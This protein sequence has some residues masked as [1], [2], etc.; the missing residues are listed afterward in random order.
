MSHVSTRKNRN[1]LICLEKTVTVF[2]A[3]FVLQYFAS[4]NSKC[5]RLRNAGPERESEKVQVSSLTSATVMNV[6]KVPIAT[7]H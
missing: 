5:V 6:A 3:L 7:C 2:I 4:D 1:I